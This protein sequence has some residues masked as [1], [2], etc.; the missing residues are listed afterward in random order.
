MIAKN[1]ARHADRAET[2]EELSKAF[3]SPYVEEFKA[4][5]ERVNLSENLKKIEEEAYNCYF[6]TKESIDLLERRYLFESQIN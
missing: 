6:L 4:A 1:A 5:E 3:G 2:R